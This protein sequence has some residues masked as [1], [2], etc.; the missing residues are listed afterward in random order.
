MGLK[1][2]AQQIAGILGME[3]IYFLSNDAGDSFLVP[4][5]GEEDDT[6]EGSAFV[7]IDP[8][9]WGESQTVVSLRSYVLEEVDID[10]PGREPLLVE[11]NR[12]N[13]EHG[14]GK[15]YLDEESR[16]IVLEHHLLGDDLDREEL[17]TALYAIGS[18]ADRLDDE[19]REKLGTG[20][21]ARDAWKRR[22]AEMAGEGTAIDA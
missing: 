10:K 14:F 4:T 19:V 7:Y 16:M 13:A 18:M 6:S 8:A 15:F 9:E 22:E 5:P 1:Q 12:L 17:L 21:R 11:L 2:V 3:D 20:Q